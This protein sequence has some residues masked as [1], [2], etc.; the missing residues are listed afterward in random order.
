MQKESRLKLAIALSFSFMLVEIV[1]GYLANSI[2]IYSDAAHLLTDIAG[3]GIALLAAIASRAPS[4]KT[5]TFGFARAE[6]F[7]ALGS[8]AS[9][10][11]ITFILLYAAYVRAISWYEGNPEPVNGFLMF[12][13]ACF[14]V[15]VNL[16]LGYVFHDEHGGDFH[17]G[18]SHDH[19]H[20]A[21]H[22]QS[23]IPASAAATCDHGHHGHDHGHGHGHD[24]HHQHSCGQDHDHGHAHGH[25]HDSAKVHEDHDHGHDHNDDCACDD[26]TCTGHSHSSHKHSSKQPA[27]D[28]GHDHG[29]NEST[30]L[31]QGSMHHASYQ[32]ENLHD[33]HAHVHAHHSKDVNI[34]A[35]Y[36][37]VLTDLIQSIGVAIAG[38]ILWHY[39]NYEIIDPVCT[40][41]FSFIALSSTVPLIKRVSL[42]LFEGTPSHIDWEIVMQRLSNIPGVENV[43][44]LHIWSISS[45]SISLTC[46]IRVSAALLLYHQMHRLYHFTIILFTH[47]ILPYVCRREIRK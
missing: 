24:N 22:S 25:G 32:A 4:T 45:K 46:H 12:A 19:G 31:L 21:H 1:G 33:G 5:L 27:C 8:I 39:P 6:V 30:P 40:F 28:H 44:D 47:N 15:F 17:P 2:A 7:G 42:I 3:F 10:W 20:C 18:H 43:H 26:E 14:G 35:A 23:E 9:L 11:V 34:E 41:I 37:H 36:L 13:V 16:C 29:H 38:L